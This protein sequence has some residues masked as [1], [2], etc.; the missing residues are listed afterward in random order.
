MK[1]LENDTFVCVGVSLDTL[2]NGPKVV[3]RPLSAFGRT[4]AHLMSGTVNRES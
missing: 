1:G 2:G 4:V 3:V